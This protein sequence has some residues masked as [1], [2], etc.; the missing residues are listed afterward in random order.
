MNDYSSEYIVCRKSK[1]LKKDKYINI[2]NHN[3][4]LKKYLVFLNLSFQGYY[5]KTNI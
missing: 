1:I 5:L 2:F 3:L 4:W